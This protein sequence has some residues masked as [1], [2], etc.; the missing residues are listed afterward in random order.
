VGILGY[1]GFADAH[2]AVQGAECAAAFPP[3]APGA[4]AAGKPPWL[5]SAD[6]A[7]TRDARTA[8]MVAKKPAHKS[9]GT[10]SRL[11]TRKSYAKLSTSTG[12]CADGRASTDLALV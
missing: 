11:D 6:R 2:S 12:T 1:F 3:P 8:L 9:A 4:L 10:A 7:A 5:A